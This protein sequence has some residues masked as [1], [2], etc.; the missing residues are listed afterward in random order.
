MI[1]CGVFAYSI[2]TIG[3]IFQEG[4]KSKK[5][6]QDKMTIINDYMENK[7]ISTELRFQIREYL[8]YSWKSGTSEDTD[9]SKKI[10]SQLSQF[11]RESIILES[12]QTAL[13]SPILSKNFS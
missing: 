3:L 12:C 5:D 7:K 2:N 11:L 13:N 4:N 8:N 1:S 6:L 10:I 9:Q